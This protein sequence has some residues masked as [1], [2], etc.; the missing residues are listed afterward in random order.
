MLGW[1]EC[2]GN[3][4]GEITS[5]NPTPRLFSYTI[6]IDDGAAPNPFHGMCTLAICKPG[7]RRV[8]KK[9]DWIAGRRTGH[10]LLEF[11]HHPRLAGP[12]IPRN[13]RTALLSRTISSAASTPTHLPTFDFGTVVI[14]STI[15]RQM[16]RGPFSS[17]GS[18]SSLNKGAS[19]GSR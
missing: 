11:V 18:T 5:M 15:R 4:R 13:T 6:P 1:W 9:G 14:L 3:G 16:P 17:F 7:I 10:F 19:V 2:C 12:A 8:A